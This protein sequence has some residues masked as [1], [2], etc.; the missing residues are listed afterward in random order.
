MPAEQSIPRPTP[1]TEEHEGQLL[2][3]FQKYTG[4]FSEREFSEDE[5]QLVEMIEKCNVAFILCEGFT[6][7]ALVEAT[8]IPPPK[9]AV[10][11]VAQHLIAHD[12]FPA[13][14]SSLEGGAG[15][16]GREPTEFFGYVEG[17]PLQHKQQGSWYKL[18]IPGNAVEDVKSWFINNQDR[19]YCARG[20]PRVSE[21]TGHLPDLIK[22]A[23]L[24][25][26]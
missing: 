14:L 12:A 4:K 21:L 15:G 2:Q 23:G 6:E 22:I 26:T 9:S 16:T 24:R 7:G 8:E 11:R 13:R 19:V 20:M 18:N 3:G 17:L 25:P 5:K 1:S 10:F